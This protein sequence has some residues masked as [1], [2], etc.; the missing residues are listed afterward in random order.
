MTAFIGKAVDKSR[1]VKMQKKDLVQ[2]YTV[3]LLGEGFILLSVFP[4]ETLRFKEIFL[5]F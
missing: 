1:D 3:D 4:L 5:L 2:P